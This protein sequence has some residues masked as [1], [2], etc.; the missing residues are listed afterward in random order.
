VAL[1][2]WL[3]LSL[4]TASARTSRR[5]VEATR[6]YLE[7]ESVFFRALASNA[8]R[9]VVA[10]EELA[11]RLAAE[12]PGVAT[13]SGAVAGSEPRSR[14]KVFEKLRSEMVYAVILAFV[15]PDLATYRHVANTLAHLHWSS[16]RLTAA[17]HML[18]KEG[19]GA[20]VE[21][22]D[23][24]GDFRE[25][26]ASGYTRLPPKTARFLA[27]AHITIGERGP[28][29]QERVESMLKRYEGPRERSLR[30][31]L[32][33]L[34]GRISRTVSAD[35]VPVLRKVER[36]LGLHV[37]LEERSGGLLIPA[38]A[39]VVAS[40]GERLAEF[41]RGRAVAAQSGCLACHRIGEDGNLGPG[42]DL[43][44]IRSRLTGVQIAHARINP[45][46]PMPSFRNLPKARFEALVEFL[47][48]LR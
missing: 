43:T 25:W 2:P 8:H 20:L 9:G 30:R 22:P 38:P 16:R 14:V 37:G 41:Y 40:G 15:S 28:D 27:E 17:V 47:S 39:S 42:P 10:G 7:A 4:T 24:C 36:V 6:S 5:D 31:R 32:D 34:R 33:R 21:P 48:L 3:L 11:T 29:L 18:A 26:A 1:A 44:H 45:K 13:G 19:A 35:L 23:L 46:A 12:C